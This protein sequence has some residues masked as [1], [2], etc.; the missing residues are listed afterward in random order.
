MKHLLGEHALKWL[1]SCQKPVH[2]E[3]FW[4]SAN[5]E[6]L[7]VSS[8]YTFIQVVIFAHLEILGECLVTGGICGTILQRRNHFLSASFWTQQK[9]WLEKQHHLS[10]RILLQGIHHQDKTNREEQQ[11]PHLSR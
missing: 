9:A 1:Y 8:N 7:W 2:I 10:W 6:P 4:Q 11:H 5:L 3:H